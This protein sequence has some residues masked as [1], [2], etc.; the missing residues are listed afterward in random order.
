[1]CEKHLERSD[2]RELEQRSRCQARVELGAQIRVARLLAQAV[3]LALEYDGRV[4]L[5]EEED[6]GD[7]HDAGLETF[8]SCRNAVPGPGQEETYGDRDDPEDPSPANGFRDEATRD[9][10]NDG[11]HQ[12]THGPDGHGTTPLFLNEQVC[13]RA[14]ADR[15]GYRSRDALEEAEANEHVEIAAYGAGDSEDYEED[16]AN[17]VDWEAAIDL[18]HWGDDDG[19][20]GIA[21]NEDG[22][23]ERSEQLIIGLE[24]REH[25]RDSRC[26]H[27]RG[28]WGDESHGRNEG[29]DAPVEQAVSTRRTRRVVEDA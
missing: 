11:T 18:A 5:F 15:E 9:W 16:V 21:Q 12:G 1:M 10:S 8:Q 24:L 22:D 26:E 25:L 2:D 20:G 6:K 4:G 17:V 3:G 28:E 23:D 7:G 29:D 13:N 19:P 14:A 27:G